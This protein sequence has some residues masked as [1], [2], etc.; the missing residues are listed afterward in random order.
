MRVRTHLITAFLGILLL[1]IA[2]FPLHVAR[3]AGKTEVMPM[4]KAAPTAVVIEASGDEPELRRQLRTKNGVTELGTPRVPF[5]QAPTGSYGFIAPQPLGMALVTQ[6]PDL[7]LERSA[8][9]SNAYEIHKLAD[10][11]GLVVGFI[12]K[13]LIAQ[14]TPENRPRN[15][16]IALCSNRS[17]KTPYIAAIP[18]IKLMV[19]RMPVRLEPKNPDSP[20]M[21]DMD[22]QGT[23]NRK[24]VPGTQ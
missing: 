10:G 11:S 24:S 7:V 15:I 19:D 23:A 3:G 22:L 5:S 20:V 1:T 12:E 13:A 8:P 16:R 9:A 14:V 6:S 17:D 18:L 4:V 21:L 2:S